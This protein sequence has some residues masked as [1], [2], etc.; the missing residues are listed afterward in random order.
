MGSRVPVLIMN[1]RFSFLRSIKNAREEG[2]KYLKVLA[3]QDGFELLNKMTKLTKTAKT[4]Q[5]SSY[6]VL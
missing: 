6:K 2:Q 5:A 1:L 4:R 3:N